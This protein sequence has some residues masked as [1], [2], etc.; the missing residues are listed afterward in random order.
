M[1]VVSVGATINLILAAVRAQ[2]TTIIENAAKEPHVV[3]VA[4]FLNAMGASVVGA[5][6]DVIKIKGVER[7]NGGTFSIIPDQIEAGTFM[8]MAAI[9]AGDVLVKNVIPKHVESITAKLLEAGVTV[10]EFDDSIRVT[11]DGNFNK[12]NIKTLPYPGFPTDLQP[13]IL[14]LLTLAEGT[15]IVTEG[16]WDNRFRYVD[17]LVKMGANITV[18]GKVAIVEGV[19]RLSGSP[20]TATDLRAGAAMLIAALAAN[21][22]T[23]IHDLTHIDRGYENFE[24]KLKALGAQ[25][26]RRSGARRQRQTG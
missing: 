11:S 7:L 24:Q 25:I 22:V 17:E 1:D 9:T 6:T 26:T 8:I 15:S 13:Q 4:N 20:V 10:E 18:D 23:E 16:V 3:D 19:K 21:G 14:T 5:G 2:G 12:I